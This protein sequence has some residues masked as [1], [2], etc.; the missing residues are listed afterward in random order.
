[1]LGEV[2]GQEEFDVGDGSDLEDCF[3]GSVCRHR[4]RLSEQLGCN[5]ARGS[6]DCKQRR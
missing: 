5:S 2:R 1:V 3:G 4:R 6:R